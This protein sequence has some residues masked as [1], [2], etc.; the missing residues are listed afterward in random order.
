MINKKMW[1]LA[2][3][4]F[5]VSFLPAQESVPLYTIS[6]PPNARLLIVQNDDQ[7]KALT[8][9]LLLI[10]T[11][12]TSHFTRIIIIRIII[13]RI[14]TKIILIMS[15][16]PI[17]ETI[18]VDFMSIVEAAMNIGAAIMAESGAMRVVMEA[19][20]TGMEATTNKESY[21]DEKNGSDLHDFS[22]VSY[23]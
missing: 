17:I 10:T 19:M 3:G 18:P 1:V 11:T 6:L 12:I 16:I 15:R 2:L 8:N 13:I 21:I 5:A 7:D 9:F 20:V 23:P 4:S 22:E 14:I